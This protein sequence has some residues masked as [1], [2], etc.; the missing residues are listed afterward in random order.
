MAQYSNT[1]SITREGESLGTLTPASYG[2]FAEGDVVL[3]E[4]VDKATLYFPGES[5]TFTLTIANNSGVAIDLVDITD[6]INA[7]VDV[8]SYKLG[9]AAT[10]D[11]TN[12]IISFTDYTL[13]TGNTVLTVIGTIAS[14]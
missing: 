8:I 13:P 4:T 6:T 12:H 10:V 1:F 2:A 3:T 9:S 5:I 7:A 14:I 11:S